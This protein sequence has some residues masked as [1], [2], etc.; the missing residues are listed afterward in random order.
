MVA[1]QKTL[2]R[3]ILLVSRYSVLSFI[4]TLLLLNTIISHIHSVT[5]TLTQ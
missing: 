1:N 4:W 2:V 5:P 3:L